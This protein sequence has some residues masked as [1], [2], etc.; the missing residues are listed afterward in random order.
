M[1]KEDFCFV[2]Q[3]EASVSYMTFNAKMAGVDMDARVVVSIDRDFPDVV[4]G[5]A[6]KADVS[7]EPASGWWDRL[8]GWPRRRRAMRQVLRDLAYERIRLGRWAPTGVQF[9]LE[10][11]A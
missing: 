6:V 1:K 4:E 5:V 8:V 10:V 9:V 11:T 7:V 2:Q 3:C